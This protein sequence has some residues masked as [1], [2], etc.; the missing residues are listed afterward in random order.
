MYWTVSINDFV[1]VSSCQKLTQ[2]L[3]LIFQCRELV[4]QYYTDWSYVAR[5]G[6]RDG[7]KSIDRLSCYHF[8]LPADL[9]VR[10]FQNIKDVFM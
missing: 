8:N 1:F 5:T 10:Q 9:A 3:N 7:L 6:F 4:Q 2:W